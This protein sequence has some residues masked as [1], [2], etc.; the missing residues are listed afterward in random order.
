MA[1]LDV[2]LASAVVGL[3]ELQQAATARRGARGSR[4]AEQAVALVCPLAESQPESKV[5]VI[6]ALAGLVAVP[7]FSVRDRD[8]AF[9]GRVDLAFP[10][11]RVAIEYDGAWHAEP[12]QFAKDRRRLNRLTAAGWTVI[13]LTA[14]DLRDPQAVVARVREA[15]VRATSGK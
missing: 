1:A 15:L 4:R 8:G 9:I 11:H 12:G 6:L 10:R 2:L 7:Q 3:G 5:R 13:H 14:A